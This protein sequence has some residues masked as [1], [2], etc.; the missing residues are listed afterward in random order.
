MPMQGLCCPMISSVVA[1]P[2]TLLV[3]WRSMPSAAHRT[4]QC[5]GTAGSSC[6]WS[7]VAKTCPDS[8]CSHIPLQGSP[9]PS[10]PLGLKE[11]EGF[12]TEAKL[13]TGGRVWDTHT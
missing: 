1:T 4:F 5:L 8:A 3:S 10:S 2:L 6:Q 11:E 13:L 12:A 9:G 7:W